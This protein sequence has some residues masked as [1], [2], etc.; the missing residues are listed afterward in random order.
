MSR[1]SEVEHSAFRAVEG[2]T[3]VRDQDRPAKR[4]MIIIILLKE[5]I[6]SLSGISKRSLLSR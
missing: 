1:A 6:E 3:A 5:E 2:S 4:T